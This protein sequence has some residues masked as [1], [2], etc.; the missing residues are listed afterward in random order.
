MSYTTLIQKTVKIRKP[1]ICIGCGKK[2]SAR[3]DMELHEGLNDGEF[4]RSYMCPIC[5]D[6]MTKERWNSLDEGLGYG[7]I[8]NFEE[9]KAHRNRYKLINQKQK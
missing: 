2:Y 5:V 7:E 8:W 4:H 9:Y 1:H 6:F 3:Q